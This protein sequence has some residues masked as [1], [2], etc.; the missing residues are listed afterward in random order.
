MSALPCWST[1]VACVGVDEDST[2]NTP[3]TGKRRNNPSIRAAKGIQRCIIVGLR[4]VPRAS[5]PP[6]WAQSRGVWLQHDSTQYGHSLTRSLFHSEQICTTRPEDLWMNSTSGFPLCIAKCVGDRAFVYVNTR[7][8]VEEMRRLC[9]GYASRNIGRELGA[10]YGAT[11]RVSR[12][13]SMFCFRSVDYCYRSAVNIHDEQ[14]LRGTSFWRREWIT[15]PTMLVEK[16]R[17]KE[18]GSSFYWCL[19]VS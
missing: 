16:K 18:N 1:V 13:T 15:T 5:K 9:L 19:W 7:L 12:S 14:E 3:N 8:S 17:E 6:Y 4:A 11:V 2:P 10:N